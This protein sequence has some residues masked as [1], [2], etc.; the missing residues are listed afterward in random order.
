MRRLRLMARYYQMGRRVTSDGTIVYKRSHRLFRLKTGAPLEAGFEP[1]LRLELDRELP[2]GRMPTFYESPA[3]IARK[4]FHEDLLAAGVSNLQ[5]VPVVIVNP[6]D[7]SQN[8]DYLLLNIVGRVRCA[9]MRRSKH[10][11]IGPGMNVVDKL[12][13]AGGVPAG[14][15]LFVADED[16]D[17]MVVSERVQQRITAKGYDD[18]WFEELS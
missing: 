8:H 18:V 9:D 12:V 5:T 14:L 17:V 2:H 3:L 13:L 16:T 15:D 11:S 1:P 7:G 6:E 10:R 4:A